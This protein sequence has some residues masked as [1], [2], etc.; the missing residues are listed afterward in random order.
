M[1]DADEIKECVMRPDSI[2]VPHSRTYRN[3][4]QQNQTK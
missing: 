1:P 4:F 3:H 2:L